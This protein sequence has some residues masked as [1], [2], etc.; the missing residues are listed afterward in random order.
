[1]AEFN[2]AKEE[3]ESS[4]ILP[5]EMERCEAITGGR[6]KNRYL[7][8]QLKFSMMNADQ[9]DII[10]SFLME[11]GV[12]MLLMDLQSTLERGARIRIL[13]GNYL[14]ITQPGAL[15]LLKDSFGDQIDLRFYNEKERSFHP[16]AYIFHKKEY[17]EI[18]IG[19]SNISKSALTSGNEWNY[20]FDIERDKDN[21]VSFYENFEDL[22]FNHSIVIEKLMNLGEPEDGAELAEGG[23]KI[24]FFKRDFRIEEWDWPHSRSQWSDEDHG[25]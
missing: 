18:Y 19:S 2:F 12:R 22:F 21:F 6:N 1:M 20:H 17:G 15:Y 5:L 11:S 10:V 14:G 23:E 7:L 25:V 24:G 13:T 4:D 9:I 8:Y 16:R 3:I